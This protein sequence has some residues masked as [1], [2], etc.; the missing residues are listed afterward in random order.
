M[1]RTRTCSALALFLALGCLGWLALAP[2][3]GAAQ[4]GF[5]VIVDGSSSV[6]SVTKADLV[7][8]FM[9]RTARWSDGSSVKPVDQHPSSAVRDAFSKAVHG[10]S[11]EAVVSHWRQQI[12]AGRAVPP[13]ER[14][15][16]AAVV[17]YVSK[18]RGA[19]GY[20]G[21]GTALGSAKPLSVRGL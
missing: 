18:N 1:L 15:G 13:P 2:T 20:V 21:P 19:V 8:I 3:P 17:S 5:I 14:K 7:K 12:F 9:R 4:V 10:R 16:D 6:E 11:T